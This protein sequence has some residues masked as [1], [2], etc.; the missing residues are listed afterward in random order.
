M[1]WQR[2]T[3][4]YLRTRER[5]SLGIGSCAR[6]SDSRDRAKEPARG[7]ERENGFLLAHQSVE[8]NGGD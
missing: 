2:Q 5:T 3:G 6:T 8:L 4:S 1:Q 7:R